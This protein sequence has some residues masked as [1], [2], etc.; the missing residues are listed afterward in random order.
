MRRRAFQ[1][2]NATMTLIVLAFVAFFFVTEL[3]PLAVTAM[4]GAIACGVL[5]IIPMNTGVLRSV[6]LHGGSVCGDVRHRRGDVPY[7]TGPKI[8]VTVVKF[9]GTGENS[10]MIGSMVV[11]AA[12][13]VGYF[14]HRHHRLPDSGYRRYLRKRPASRSTV[15]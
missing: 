10:L 7:R 2:D 5:G 12:L 4:A 14:Q 8:G 11:A 1:L 6:Q 13:S 9:T 15:R 3:L